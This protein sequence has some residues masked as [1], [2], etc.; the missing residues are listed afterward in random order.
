MMASNSPSSAT[1]LAGSQGEETLLSKSFLGLLLT[2]LLGATNDNIL[3]WLVI[4]VGK[5]YFPSWVGWILMAGTAAFVLPYILLAAPAGYLAD[6]FSKRTVIVSCKIAEV[7]IM[8]LAILGIVV[9]SVTMMLL[10][11]AL[12]GAQSALFGP[13]KLGSI[14][15]MLHETKISAA[16]G[17]IGLTTVI[18]TTIGM[19]IGNWLTV[20]SGAKGQEDWWLSAMVLLSVAGLGWGAS[21]FIKQLPIAN[22]ERRFPWNMAGQTMRDL[23]TL[24]QQRAMLRVALGIMFFWSLG[25]LAQ[26][27]IDQFAFEGGA[28]RQTQVTPLL[29]SLVVGVG[30]G[31]VLAGFWS[32]GRV[33]L[34]IL[35][36]GAGGLAFTSLLLFTLEGTLITPVQHWTASY[37]AACLILF[38]LGSSAG[39]FDVPLAAY[40]QH[41]SRPKERG[42]ILAASN[43]L[44]FSGMLLAALAFGLMR[45]PTTEGTLD[46]VIAEFGEDFQSEQLASR[47]WN[48]M[49]RQK[50]EGHFLNVKAYIQRYPDEEQ[51]VRSVYR[52][53]GF[54]WFWARQIFLL[55]GVLTIPVF[56]YILCLIPQ[57]TIR[58][59]AWL[60]T[61]TA[62]QVRVFQRFHLPE[63]GPA[64]LVA[65]HISWM[66]GLLLVAVSPRPIRLIVSTS[67]LGSWWAQGLGRIMGAIPVGRS[68]K[69]ALVAIQA[70][71]QA[72]ADGELVCI[73]PEGGIS[74]SGQLQAF[75]A[76]TLEIVRES[77]ASVVPVYLDELWGSIFTFHGGRLFWKR[78]RFRARRVSI[79]FG[80]P[81]DR[82]DEI[83]SV[84]QAVM[85]LSAVAVAGRRERMMVLSRSMIRKCRKALFRWKIADS[86]GA[87]LTGGS[88]LLRSLILR[89]L[90]LREVLK[91]DEKYIGILLPPSV[92]AVVTNA[93]LTLAKRVTVNLNY[94]TSSSVLNACIRKA[95]IT[96]VLTSRKL[97]EKLDLQIDAE[98]IV[99]EDYR[100][101]ISVPDKLF[102]AIQAYATPAFLLDRLFGLHQL[103]GDDELTVIFTSGSTGDPKGVVLSYHNLGTNV[104]AVEQVVHLRSSDTLLGILPFFHSFGFMVTLWAPLGLD[105]RCAYHFNPLDA[106]EVGKLARR[107]RTTVMLATPTFLRT[108]L[109]RCQKEDFQ[110]LDTVVTGAEKMPMPLAE[111]FDEKFNVRPVEGYGITELSPLVSVN[112]PPSRM[113]PGGKDGKFGTVGRPIPGVAVKIVDP[114][115]FEDLATD[116]DGMLLVK[117][118]N[119]MKGYMGQPD[120]TAAVMHGDWFIT[121]DISRIDR[122]GFIQITGRLSRFSKIGGEM[123]PHINIEQKIQKMLDPNEE[124]DSVCAVVTSVRDERKGERLIVLHTQ[125]DQTADAI[126]KQL[127]AAGLPNLWIP[128]VDSFLQVDA[129]PLLG[130]GK[131]DL[132]GMS[133][134]AEQHLGG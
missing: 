59:L 118:P 26:L 127:A 92:G 23:R 123:V 108:Y 11:V 16:N 89:R 13:S 39:L 28:T 81:L 78:P 32:G 94:T 101:K 79:W 90:L 88:L 121:G 102:A 73:F 53:V 76:G 15:E 98:V 4:G 70:A 55:C 131:L 116:T 126:C 111:A 72:L 37:I 21:L 122:Q 115:S 60:V 91:E 109:R 6:A 125:I 1:E 105:V 80:P 44:T 132:K 99:L 8:L 64:L 110:T 34:G 100:E 95:G 29:A 74:R 117:G 54:P 48:Q 68:P 40:M 63:T 71:R 5:Q 85:D 38:L 33:E 86:S 14:P 96:H 107:W 58:F 43:F 41:F 56:V 45:S 31:S 20:A 103:H 120:Q 3:R 27:N 113:Q 9:G 104:E 130:T 133:N 67:L 24:S 69:E 7:A 49:Q 75:K 129:I 12:M 30:L 77:A 57:A 36:L 134:L 35:P 52:H 25:A 114:D 50:E 2:Q 97:L 62:Y 47:L 66:D 119:V 93:A 10:V 112:V 42:S 82:P 19:V 84:R 128:S 61:H 18:A 83:Q 17:L 46:E 65:N 51:L 106:R 124:Q 22:P 87:H